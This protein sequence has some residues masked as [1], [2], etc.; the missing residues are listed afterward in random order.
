MCPYDVNR[1]RRN[2]R[3]RSL[4]SNGPI[5]AN[6]NLLVLSGLGAFA[7]PALIGKPNRAH[8]SSML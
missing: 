4:V 3:A 6:R 5:R 2:E 7:A 8:K 1:R